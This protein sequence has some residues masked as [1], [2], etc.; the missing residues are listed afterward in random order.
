MPRPFDRVDERELFACEAQQGSSFP[1]AIPL[2]KS[3]RY[4]FKATTARA[5]AADEVAMSPIEWLTMLRDNHQR[6]ARVFSVLHLF[7]GARRPGDVEDHVAK[8]AIAED[9][10]VFIYTVDLTGNAKWDL[11]DPRVFCVIMEAIDEGLVD[12]G[13]GGPPCSTWSVSRWNGGPGPRPVRLRGDFCWGLRDLTPSE[14]RRVKEG[15]VLLNTLAAFEGISMRS[16]PPAR[17]PRRPG[18]LSLREY[19]GHRAGATVRAP[20]RFQAQAASS[21]HDWADLP[22]GD[23]HFIKHGRQRGL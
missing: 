17:T 22:Q 21:M 6:D 20:H 23:L 2:E 8:L 14:S 13:L 11:A 9:L 10:L 18:G 5:P 19:L 4:W 7:G 1:S 15:N 3:D 12:L 16:R